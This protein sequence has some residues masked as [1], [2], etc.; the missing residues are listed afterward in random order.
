MIQDYPGGRVTL[1]LVSW[2]LQTVQEALRRD[3]FW[4]PKSPHTAHAHNRAK[5]HATRVLLSCHKITYL[6]ALP[7]PYAYFHIMGVIMTFN[8]VLIGFYF[9]TFRTFGSLGPYTFALLVYMGLREVS[10]A[11]ADP[12]G[13]DEVD[14]PVA[15]FLN[16]AFDHS[17]GLLEAFSSSSR[18]RLQK[19]ISRWQPFSDKEMLVN[20]N[21]NM[22]YTGKSRSEAGKEI[23]W[24]SKM[25]LQQLAES[26]VNVK[27]HMQRALLSKEEQEEL[28]WAARKKRQVIM[29]AE[30][31]NANK[32][33]WPEEVV[34]MATEAL[35]DCTAFDGLSDERLRERM[36]REGLNDDGDRDSLVEKLERARLA[37]EQ[38]IVLNL[39]KE[40]AAAKERLEKLRKITREIAEAGRQ[41]AGAEPDDVEVEFRPEECTRCHRVLEEDARFC[42]T[43]GLR[44]IKVPDVVPDQ[45]PG[46]SPGPALLGL[47]DGSPDVEA[48]IDPDEIVGFEN[49]DQATLRIRRIMEKVR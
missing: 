36:H 40:L 5:K 37:R 46:V 25:P 12:F 38:G 1:I 18:T 45:E 14:F 26:G 27:R 9:A 23:S 6:M 33:E 19:Q 32:A 11:L 7:I 15:N 35:E 21:P 29:D 16:Y 48:A 22:I 13:Q 49:F 4:R 30:D 2:A 20:H 41:D 34:R 43:C 3:C 17:V 42:R 24:D 10:I 31:S 47:T 28:S 39:T 44:R 8:F